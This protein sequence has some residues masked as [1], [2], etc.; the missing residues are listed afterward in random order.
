MATVLVVDDALFMRERFA[1]ILRGTEFTMVGE[2]GGGAEAALACERLQPDLILMD[3]TMPFMG[4]IE[5]TRRI[6]EKNQIVRI[7]LYCSFEELSRIQEGIAAGI[8]DF[9]VK[10]F[11]ADDVLRLL[12]ACMRAELPG[13]GAS[14]ILP[15]E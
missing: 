5:A 4:G 1:E 10:P 6:R 9:F 13:A 3:L 15:M 11:E 7:L 14:R 8:T 2:A 12:E